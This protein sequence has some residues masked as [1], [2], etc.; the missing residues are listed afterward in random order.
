MMSKSLTEVISDR[1]ASSGGPARGTVRLW[2]VLRLVLALI[3][4]PALATAA[5]ADIFRAGEFTLVNGSDATSFDFTASIPDA[6]DSE[7]KVVWPEGCEQTAMSRRLIGTR[8]LYAF[9]FRCDRGLQ[10]GDQIRTPWKLDGASFVSN[11]AGIQANRSLTG[12]DG[13]ITVPIGGAFSGARPVPEIAAEY[14]HQ[15][16]LHIWMGWDHLAFVLCLCMLASGRKL[17]WLVTAFTAGHSVS[18]A[19]AFFELVSVP[20]PPVEAIIALSIAFMAREA[21]M[22][23]DGERDA[24]QAFRRELTVVILFGLIH[25]LGFASALGELG[26]QQAERV[27]AL[28]F[29]NLGVEAG[30]LVFVGAV[31][32]LMI[33]LRQV[34]LATPVR[35]AAMYGVGMLG[36]F[37][38]VERIA[39][40]TLA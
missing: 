17:L 14:L 23:R 36:A 16:V 37:W 33:L 24:S 10:T 18:L 39:G 26:V 11:I 35:T 40:F 31:T 25:G 5:R 19:L 30:Q 12:A 34:A 28:I 9:S 8:A 29:F 21:L 1:M 15:G 22:L 38:M 27:P 13:G 7:E 4:L 20:I 6:A 2:T 32:G 3:A